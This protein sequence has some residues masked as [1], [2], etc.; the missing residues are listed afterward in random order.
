V[1][2]IINSKVVGVTKLNK[3]GTSRQQIIRDLLYNGDPLVLKRE[4]QNEFDP[5]AIA[6]YFDSPS[7][8]E[9]LQVGYLPYGQ[10]LRLAPLMDCGR[11]I[12][13]EV[14]AVTQSGPE[15]LGVE[16]TLKIL[17]Q[18]EASAWQKWNELLSKGYLKQPAHT[19]LSKFSKS[20]KNVWIALLLWLF[21]GIF[22]VHRWFVGRGSWLYSLTLGY[23]LIGWLFDFFV[24]LLGEFKDKDGRRVWVV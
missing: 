21:L 4:P 10:A 6:V 11:V 7:I 5:N 19:T 2:E 15:N 8:D 13:A 12:T 9:F 14:A 16:I 1:A 3:D 24:I 23:L 17:N 20:K 18:E 22:G